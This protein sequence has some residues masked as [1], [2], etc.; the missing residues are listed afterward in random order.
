MRPPLQSKNDIASIDPFK[1]N[2]GPPNVISQILLRDIELKIRENSPKN[3]TTIGCAFL[4][5][6]SGSVID[7]VNTEP[8]LVPSHSVGSSADGSIKKTLTPHN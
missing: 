7:T 1:R 2:I 3:D 8:K 5:S 6:E 4:L